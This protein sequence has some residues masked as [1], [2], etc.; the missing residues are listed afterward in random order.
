MS[1][2]L[3]VS[4]QRIDARNS[5]YHKIIRANPIY[6]VTVTCLIIYALLIFIA[7]RCR[8]DLT[9][10]DQNLLNSTGL[11]P[12]QPIIDANLY[13]PS[14]YGLEDIIEDLSQDFHNITQ[15]DVNFTITPKEMQES[16][17]ET[18]KKE[19]DDYDCN[20]VEL[21]KLLYD[22]RKYI[23]LK[24][25]EEVQPTVIL[26]PRQIP[27][28]VAAPLTYIEPKRKSNNPTNLLEIIS[29]YN[30]AA[31]KRPGS[32]LKTFFKPKIKV[33]DKKLIDKTYSMNPGKYIFVENTEKDQGKR[34]K[35]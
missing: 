26:T 30:N 16:L 34:M 23:D 7:T 12:E 1:R 24:K 4:Y 35:K 31:K 2:K 27:A 28:P 5:R 25:Q 9:K 10:K 15:D 8:E 22:A 32:V 17:L 29:R 33:P 21:A 13:E 18:N 11:L 20:L 19:D 3:N 14:P 6:I